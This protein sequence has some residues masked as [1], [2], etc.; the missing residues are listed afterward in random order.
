MNKKAF[1]LIELSIVILI[2]GILIAGV[3]QSSRMINEYK[4]T[5]ARNL[6]QSSPVSSVPDLILWLESTSEKSFASAEQQESGQ[7]I[8]TW[9]DINPQSI[10][11]SNLTQSTPGSRP[12]YTT[13]LINSLPAIS[14]DG[15]D[16]QMLSASISSIEFSPKNTVT[17][18]MVANI[19]SAG[20]VLFKYEFDGDNRLGIE[21]TGASYLR[22]DFPSGGAGTLAGSTS[23]ANQ[24]II[25]TAHSNKT[26]QTIFVNGSSYATQANTLSFATTFSAQII[27]G[28][29]NGDA[30]FTQADIGEVILFNRALKIEERQ[31][32]E[33]YLSKKWGIKLS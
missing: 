23:I 14:F 32:I 28:A 27:L 29:S 3:T 31:A 11:P 10:S 9:Y 18:F 7:T 17:L 24:N 21:I 2:I 19:K 30:L 20:T 6:T 15:V 12:T 8:S 4:L 33:A 5:N 13:N 22:F 1:S 16:D 26:N 25:M